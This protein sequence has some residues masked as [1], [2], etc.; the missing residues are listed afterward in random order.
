[1]FG[2]EGN[3]V[4]HIKRKSKASVFVD[5]KGLV[6]RLAGSREQVDKA[7][8]LIAEILAR[9]PKDASAKDVAGAAPAAAAE[10]QKEK[11]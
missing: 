7:K 11:E 3:T 6:V 9:Q 10:E 2:K 4:K 5:S 8:S 1:M